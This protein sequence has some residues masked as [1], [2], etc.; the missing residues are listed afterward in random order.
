MTSYTDAGNATPGPLTGMKHSKHTIPKSLPCRNEA[1]G[2][3]DR[4]RADFEPTLIGT[5]ILSRGLDG[6]RISRL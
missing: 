5:I 6:C 1:A 3:A 2:N 4:L